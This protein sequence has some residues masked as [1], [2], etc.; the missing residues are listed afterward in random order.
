MLRPT[1]LK[2]LERRTVR[3]GLS[4]PIRSSGRVQPTQA[5]HRGAA[6]APPALYHSGDADDLDGAESLDLIDDDVSI[7]PF[8]RPAGASAPAPAP[9][10][11][12]HPTRTTRPLTATHRAAAGEVHGARGG[13]GS[14]AEHP[15]EQWAADEPPQRPTLPV[16][17]R[18]VI[19]IA[20]RPHG[21]TS[22]AAPA[23]GSSAHGVAPL[24]R[25][26]RE[27]LREA[28]ADDADGDDVDR[29]SRHPHAGHAEDTEDGEGA[30]AADVG[31]AGSGGSGAHLPS[32]EDAE[33]DAVSAATAAKSSDA[34][35]FLL[36]H[37]DAEIAALQRRHASVTTRRQSVQTRQTQRIKELFDV[38]EHPW[39][40]LPSEVQPALPATGVDVYIKEQQLARQQQSPPQDG[41]DKMYVLALHKNYKSMPAG[42]KRF[43]EEAAHY[44]AAVREELKYQLTRG[45]A[46]FE[47]FLDTIK[48]CTM[49]MAREGKMPELPSTHAQNR[50]QAARNNAA[51][52]QRKASST[53]SRRPTSQAGASE[54]SSPLGA[55][56][57]GADG[58]GAEARSTETEHAGSGTGRGGRQSLSVAAGS[59]RSVGKAASRVKQAAKKAKSAAGTAGGAAAKGRKASA[60]A[61][62]KKPAKSKAAASGGAKAKRAGAA[63]SG[64]RGKKRAAKA[65]SAGGSG[66]SRSIPL[67][68][69]DLL[70]LMKV[71]QMMN[72]ATASG[73][74]GGKKAGKKASAAAPKAAAAKKKK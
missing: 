42:R 50:F 53:P 32:A 44:N 65:T 47:A 41:Q 67:P 14:H 7:E 21:A 8:G 57:A 20:R 1:L 48:E 6:T 43:Y 30:A 63:G 68:N 15:E 66:S 5:G 61:S 11:A 39:T 22:E 45:C 9:R 33:G 46:R 49:E 26:P 69:L 74:R 51:A 73:G 52:Q 59:R 27:P 71:K 55:A 28:V 35:R 12:P 31:A 54:S 62:S 36:N 70:A 10:H 16:P 17:A 72:G 60:P 4:K 23:H 19:T 25:S 13:G 38:M 18:R 58:N 40:L 3:P 34:Y 37:I 2:W 29:S 24:S 56:D 64:G